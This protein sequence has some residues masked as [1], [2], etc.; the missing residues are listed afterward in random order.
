MNRSKKNFFFSKMAKKKL[1]GRRQNGG[2]VGK[3]QTNNFFK[4]GLSENVTRHRQKGRQI[5]IVADRQTD[6]LLT[7]S[8]FT[9]TTTSLLCFQ[10]RRSCGSIL[11]LG[12]PSMHPSVRSSKTVPARV[13][14]FHIWIPHGK[15]SCPSY[16]HFWSCALLKKSE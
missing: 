6:R 10:L 13:L 2:S 11:V 3:Q 8:V 16:F 1:L 5:Q 9:Y 4:V 7:P 12:C 14:K 15:I